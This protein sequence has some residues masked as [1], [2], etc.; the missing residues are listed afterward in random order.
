MM[1]TIRMKMTTIGV[2]MNNGHSPRGQVG[3]LANAGGL[4]F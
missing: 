1:M 3:P 2:T 4:L